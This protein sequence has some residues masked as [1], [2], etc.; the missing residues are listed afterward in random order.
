MAGLATKYLL[1]QKC[2]TPRILKN[3]Q[4]VGYFEAARSPRMRSI[5][6]VCE[7]SEG[8][9]DAKRAA[10]CGFYQKGSPASNSVA[11]LCSYSPRV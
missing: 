10:I 9:A 3:S 4:I 8:E 5:L 1:S 6:R 2:D 7:Q 11:S